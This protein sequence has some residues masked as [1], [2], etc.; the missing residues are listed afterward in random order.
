M[1][2]K[3]LKVRSEREWFKMPETSQWLHTPLREFCLREGMSKAAIKR[4]E[5]CVNSLRWRFERAIFHAEKAQSLKERFQKELDSLADLS[6]I[7]NRARIMFKYEAHVEGFIQSL[8]SLG[9]ILGQILNIV[10]LKENFPE[11][12]VTLH[13]IR[14]SDFPPT[15]KNALDDLVNS[16]EY[17]YVEAFCN[18][19]KHRRLIHAAYEGGFIEEFKVTGDFL[20]NRF[21]YKNQKYY[22]TK[23]NDILISYKVA[24]FN[25]I[26]DVG[27]AI[28]DYAKR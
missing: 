19:I 26:N 2:E 12:T 25:Y 27:K 10:I 28:Y 20:F 4:L 17:R 24:V 3:N 6:H 22:E 8:H 11:E 7:R 15:I 23:G 5:I 9:D 13:K 16:R 18:I 21:C 14:S 1:F